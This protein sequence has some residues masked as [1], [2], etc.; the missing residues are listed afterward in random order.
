MQSAG[1]N[2][3]KDVTYNNS[4]HDIHNELLQVNLNAQ[5][6]VNDLVGKQGES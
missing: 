3:H 4:L 1:N 5:Q 2:S 6:F